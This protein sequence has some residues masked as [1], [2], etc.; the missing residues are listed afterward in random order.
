MSTQQATSTEIQT[1]DRVYVTQRGTDGPAGNATVTSFGVDGI[2]QPIARVRLDAYTTQSVGGHAGTDATGQ[3]W[4]D[5][6]VDVDQLR[7][8]EA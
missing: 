6:L 1:G 7:K 5:W 3:N 4:N 8:I 2:G